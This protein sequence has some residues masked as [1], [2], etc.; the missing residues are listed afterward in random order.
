[1]DRPAPTA[2]P[3][4]NLVQLGGKSAG[5]LHLGIF[6]DASLGHSALSRVTGVEL[7]F[8]SPPRLTLPSP[9]LGSGQPGFSLSTVTKRLG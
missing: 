8:L 4:Q 2:F 9:G 6:V 3:E 7:Q 5:A 1:M